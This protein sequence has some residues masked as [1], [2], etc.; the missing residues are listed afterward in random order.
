MQ[1]CTG[2]GIECEQN[3]IQHRKVHTLYMSPY[4]DSTNVQNLPTNMQEGLQTDSG[5]AHGQMMWK[6]ENV[7]MCATILYHFNAFKILLLHSFPEIFKL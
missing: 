2:K 6:F 3:V 1:L 7:Q 4:S 5:S